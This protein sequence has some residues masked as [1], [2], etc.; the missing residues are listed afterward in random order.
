MYKPN[1]LS[2]IRQRGI[3]FTGPWLKAITATLTNKE[4]HPLVLKCLFSVF[5]E[6]HQTLFWV[7]E[8]SFTNYRNTCHFQNS[9]SPM[10]SKT[11]QHYRKTHKLQKREKS[12]SNSKKASNST[13]KHKYYRK[14]WKVKS[15]LLSLLVTLFQ[16]PLRALS[17][18]CYISKIIQLKAYHLRKI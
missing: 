12:Q 18:I 8:L 11:L 7:S 16:I 2:K 4:G 9:Q 5:T 6:C 14:H 10:P 15:Y 13:I 3:H 17:N 1:S